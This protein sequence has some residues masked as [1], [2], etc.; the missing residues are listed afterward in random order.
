MNLID[1]KQTKLSVL[2]MFMTIQA[3]FSQVNLIIKDICFMLDKKGQIFWSEINQDCMRITMNNESNEK[4][5]KDIWRTGGSKSRHDLLS[6][7]KDFNRILIEY[8]NQNKFDQG[9]ILNSTSYMY[10]HEIQK[11]LTN[12]SLNIPMKLKEFWLNFI[13]KNA[14]RVLVTIDLFNGQPVLVKSSQIYETHS[15]G[16]YQEAIDRIS[17][18]SDILIVD[19]N[20]AFNPEDKTNERIIN[21]LARNYYVHTG[22]GL[23]SIEDVNHKLRSGIRRCVIASGNDQLIESIPKDRLIVELSINEKNQV[24]IH[25]RQTN[26]GIDIIERINQL[27]QFNVN[28]ISITFV[29]TEGHLSG[30]PR[31][32]ISN[33]IHQI[34]HSIEKIFIGGGVSTIEDLEYLW[35]FDRVIPIIGSCLWKN[36]LTVANLFN[37]MI[38]FNEQNLCPAVIQDKNGLVKGLCY[39][40]NEAIEKICEERLLY[41]YSRKF[42]QLIVKG[43]TSNHFQRIIKISLD[44]DSDSI[45]LTVDS[46]KPFCHTGFFLILHIVVFIFFFR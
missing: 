44:C 4:F 31:Q 14:R 13:G 24:L 30:I 26:T 23:R 32:Q 9:E 36:K 29:K 33:L 21:E 12:Q 27:V 3:Y 38:H 10:E 1:V 6:K 17:F 5:D 43:Q 19:L 25:A 35:S 18:F 20:R 7:W 28:V 2:K 16:N 15:H 42:N 46:A 45:L 37:Q 22:G 8:F 41:R 40:N 34:P 11:L 39:V